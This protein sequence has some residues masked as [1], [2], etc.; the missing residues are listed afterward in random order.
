MAK[1]LLDLDDDLLADLLPVARQRGMTIE[2]FLAEAARQA[3]AEEDADYQPVDISAIMA[4]ALEAARAVPSGQRFHL[5]DLIGDG[6][7]NSIAPG[8]RKSLGKNFRRAVEGGAIGEY[9]GRTSANLAIY[10][11]K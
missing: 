8:P 1:L 11:R 2:A 6:V 4:T 10:E 7:W 9:K 5:T 3:L